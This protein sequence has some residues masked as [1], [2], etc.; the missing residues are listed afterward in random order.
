MPY[1]FRALFSI[2]TAL[3]VLVF[4]AGRGE[5]AFLGDTLKPFVSG[6]EMYDSNLFRVKDRGQLQQLIGDVQLHDF[7]TMVTVGTGLHYSVSREEL[8]LLLKKDFIFYRHYTSQNTDQNEASGNLA[9]TLFDK[10]KLKFDGTYK[11]AAESR[12]DYR[13]TAV[14][15]QKKTGYGVSLGYEMP[16]GVGYEAAYRR[17]AIDYSLLQFKPNEYAVDSFIGTVSYRLSPD[18]KIYAAY[19]RDDTVYKEDMPIGSTLVNNSSTADSIRFGLEKTVSPK[20]AVSCYIGYLDR[21]HDQAAG[22]DFSGVIAR[23]AATYGVTGKLGLM[24]NGERDV[25]EETYADWIYSVTDTFGI[26]L[27]YEITDKTRA[28]FYNTLS[29]KD[30]Q[31]IPG[32]GAAKRSDF[33]H[34]M[35]ICLEWSPLNRLTLNLGYQYSMRSSDNNIYNFTDHTVITGVGY[36][37]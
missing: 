14:N 36:K 34:N 19:R 28:T 27:V 25:Y 6:S 15:E 16:A 31:E 5:C 2:F 18:S 24:L 26:G 30:F 29:W 23:V 4:F 11:T 1:S 32:S 9:F 12:T 7:I 3:A 21:R 13:S 10:V 37:F 22:R 8:N 33:L 20:T 35:N 17:S